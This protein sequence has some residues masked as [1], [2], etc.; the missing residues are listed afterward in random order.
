MHI[1][2]ALHIA[3]QTARALKWA[4]IF[5]QS[6]Q[7]GGRNDFFELDTVTHTFKDQGQKQP[8]RTSKK[9]NKSVKGGFTISSFATHDNMRKSRA[10]KCSKWIHQFSKAVKVW[11]PEERKRSHLSN[12]LTMQTHKVPFFAGPLQ[13]ELVL[14]IQ[15]G[16]YVMTS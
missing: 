12:E 11:A 10:A 1:Q 7:T 14:L 2:T 5:L 8:V 4:V 6:L 13:E 9:H 3:M 16:P 15:K